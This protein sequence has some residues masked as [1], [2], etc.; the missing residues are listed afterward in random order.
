MKH[1]LAE[2][3]VDD[4]IAPDDNLAPDSVPVPASLVPRL[5]ETAVLLD[6]D[7]TLLD[8]ASTPREVWVPPDLAETLRLLH[9]R[10]D[11]ALAL[12][13]GRSLNDIDL[14]FAPD[15]FPAIGGHGAEMRLQPDSDEAVAA[16]A[17]ALDKELKRRLAA[18]AKLSPG[19]LLEDKGYSLALHYRLAPH[20]EKAI[21][22]AVSLIRADLPSAPIEVM[23]GKSVC[24]IKQAGFTKA[25][26]V[27]ELMTHEPF[28]GRRPFF[29]GDD[30]TDESVFEIMP[31]FNGLAFSVGRRATGVAGHFDTPSDVREFLARLLER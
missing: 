30:V 27:R 14:I 19:I 15:L 6:I 20:A 21:Y 5:K 31:D 9:E 11:G 24:E 10:T 17:P 29:I 3:P 25:S 7:G 22:E 28:K 1:D 4:D 26:G 12:V 16:H 18:I 13:S 8:F 23:P 2:M